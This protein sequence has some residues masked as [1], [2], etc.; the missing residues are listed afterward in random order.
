MSRSR[1][2][3]PALAL[4]LVTSLSACATFAGE[5]SIAQLQS[6]PGRYVDRNV[7]VEGVV[8]SAWG[9]PMVPFKAYRVSD[10][11]GE[12]LVLSD[13]T[14]LPSKGARVRV[15]GEVEEFAMFGGRSIGLHLR[16]KRLRFR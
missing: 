8:T 12:M 14:R 13:N 10:G 7:T 6:N 9:I 3:V 1:F 11:S 16:E 5:R 4:A 15:S 2:V